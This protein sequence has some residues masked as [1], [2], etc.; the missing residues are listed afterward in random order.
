MAICA[1]ITIPATIPFTMQTFAMFTAVTILGMK[2]GTIAIGV[3]IILGGIGF[4]IFSGFRGGPGVLFGPTGGYII[5]F[6]LIGIFTGGIIKAFGHSTTTL[7]LAMVVGLLGTYTFGTL[8]F[9]FVYSI[10]NAPESI[11]TVLSWC[12]FP[13]LIPDCLKII[14]SVLLSKRLLKFIH[15]LQ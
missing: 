10:D 8:F 3:Y 6:L 7:I 13:Y 11:F 9:I 2:N 4:P 1:F 12:V 15:H 14:L 5:G